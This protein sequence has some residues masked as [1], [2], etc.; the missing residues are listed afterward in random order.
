[1]AK[2]TR[3]QKNIIR[4]SLIDLNRARVYILNPQY[5]LVKESQTTMFPAETWVNGEGTRAVSINKE[6]GSDLVGLYRAIHALEQM[7]ASE[8][9]K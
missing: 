3:S 7:L 4:M 9:G 5:H 8:E 1:M 2:L 6:I